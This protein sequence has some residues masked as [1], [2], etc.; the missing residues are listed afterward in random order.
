M[1]GPAR[2]RRPRTRVSCLRGH[3]CQ[4]FP[5]PCPLHTDVKLTIAL[6]YFSAGPKDMLDAHV[7]ALTAREVVMGRGA[8]VGGGDGLGTIALPRPLAAG[9]L[10]VLTWPVPTRR[11]RA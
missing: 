8:E 11:S 4:R 2:K 5:Q 10:D 3:S 9:P 1:T 6:Q 7:A